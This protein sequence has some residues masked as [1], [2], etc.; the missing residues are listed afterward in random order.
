M[1]GLWKG[2]GGDTAKQYSTFIRPRSATQHVFLLVQGYN[3]LCPGDTEIGHRVEQMKPGQTNWANMMPDRQPER[4][5][6]QVVVVYHIIGLIPAV[7]SSNLPFMC[8]HL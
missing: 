4:G 8:N 2:L 1:C 3:D 5:A 7:T 6:G